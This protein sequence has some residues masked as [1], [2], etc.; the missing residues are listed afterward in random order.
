MA[1]ESDENNTL[2]QPLP[3][4]VDTSPPEVS[5]A[6]PADGASRAQVERISFTLLDRYGGSVDTAAVSASVVVTDDGG[7]L[8]DGVL[9]AAG[10]QF[11]FTPA[12]VPLADGRYRVG[13]SAVDTAGNA[14]DHALVF[15]VDGDAPGGL[16]ITGGGVASGVIQI[17]PVTNRAKSGS[18]TLT[19][20]REDLTSV[21]VNNRLRVAMGTGDWSTV[22]YLPEGESALEV[23]LQDGAGNRSASVWVDLLVDSVAPAVRSLL[24]ADGSFLK[25]APA[26]IAVEFEEATSGLDPAGCLLA[27]H[28][29]DQAPVS[30]D[31]TAAGNQLS[32][33]PQ[34]E[35]AE[36]SYTVTLQ[37]QD[38]LGN[39]AAAVQSHF[40]LDATP[41][42][43][44]AVDPVASP[45]PTITQVIGGSKEA[46]A[47]ILLNGAEVVGHSPE[48]TWECTANLVSGPNRLTFLARDRAGN[49]SQG[50][51]VEIVCDDLPPPAVSALTADGRGNGTTVGLSWAGYDEAAHGDVAAYRIYH[52]TQ[53]FVDVSGLSARATAAAGQFTWRAEGLVKG[54]VYWF[55][56]V[57]V[58]RLGNALSAVSPVSAA[59]SDV[60]APEDVAGLAVNAHDDRLRFTWQP[61]ADSAGDLA[62]YRV[63]FNAAA[64]GE[65]LSAE[66]TAFEIGGLNPATAYPFRICAVDHDGNQSAG[67]SLTGITLL[68]N[69]PGLSADAHSGCVDLVWQAVQPAAYVKHYRVY[70]SQSAFATVAGMRPVF[71]TGATS[72]R[73]AGLTDHTPYWFAVTTVNLTGGERLSVVPVSATP[74]A[75]AEGPQISS[76]RVGETLLAA[77]H[78]FERSA[79]I[80]VA[81]TDPAGVSRVT[82]SI[83]GVVFATAYNA[84]YSGFLDIAPIEDGSHTVSIAAHDTLGNSTTLEFPI[85][86]VMAPPEAPRITQ[87]LGG[88]VTSQPAMTVSGRAEKGATVR[89]YL[90]AAPH[91]SPIAVDV[92]GH[93]NI[94]ATLVEGENRLWAAAENR[95]GIGP[96]SPEVRVTLD[97]TLPRS[98]LGLSAQARAGGEVRLA[99]QMPPQERAAGF[100]VY[101][102]AGTFA[103][104]A[105]AEKVTAQPITAT[106]FDDLPPQDGT[107]YYRVVAVDAALNQGAPSNEA[108]AVSDGTPPRALA[109][110]YAPQGKVDSVSGAMA[111]GRVLVDLTV[112]EALQAAPFL[113]ITP[114]GGLPVAVDLTQAD[115]TRYT[116]VFTIFEST[117]TATAYAVFSARDRAGN[118]GT[119][120]DDGASIAIDTDGPDV[121][122]LS[123]APPEPIK[124]DPDNPVIIS[125]DIG[126][127]EA[128]EAGT[129]PLIECRLSGEGRP[130]LSVTAP[131]EIAPR[132]GERQCW[133]ARVALPADAG[134]EAPETLVVTY[135][136]RDALENLGD[137]ILCQN[138]FQIYQGGLPPLSPPEGVVATALPGGRIRLNWQAVEDA[139]GYQIYRQAPGENALAA[140]LRCDEVLEWVDDPGQE[141]L[142][143]Y[144]IASV[145]QVN[146]ETAESAMSAPS[147]EALADA[148]P[149]EAPWDLALELTAQGVR[150]A[151]QA[152]AGTE[153]L[154]YRLYR[155][156]LAAITT[157]ADLSPVITGI[158]QPATVDSR[159]SP[160]AHSYVATAVDAA[161]NESAPSNSAYLNAGLL[162]VATL[163]VVQTD[164]AAPV[165]SWTHPG[166]GAVGFDLFLGAPDGGIRL[167]PALLTGAAFTDTGWSGDA[168]AYT[169]VAV[170]ANNARSLGRTVNLPLLETSLGAA[171]RLQRGV[172]NRLV[173]AV[174]NR[175]AE[176]VANVRLKT[177]LAGREHLSETFAVA[178]GAVVHVPVT[179][180][181][182][183]ELRDSEDLL[184]TLEITPHEGE[185]VRIA[186]T[187]EIPVDDGA[188]VLQVLTD[189]F[190]RGGTGEVRFALTNTGDSAIEIV[191]ARSTGKAAS[192]EITF[193]LLDAD[194]NVL[195]V[196]AFKQALG[197]GVVTLA[198]GV[199]VARMGA[200]ETFTSE[201][202]ALPVP[203][204]AP[205][206]GVVRL[207]I[208]GVYHHL[209]RDDEVVMAGPG[210]RYGVTL[211][212]TAYLGEVTGI[213]PQISTG[214][215]TVVINGRALA[216]DS[217]QPMPHV[218][219]KLIITLNGFERSV[220]VFS[221]ADGTFAHGFT[222]LAGEGGT[223]A[224]GAVH[225]DVTDRPLQG[226][227]VISKLS[228]SPTAATL[229]LPKNY[230]QR[231]TLE[232]TAGDGREIRNLQ[233]VWAATDQPEGVLPQG[234][235]L[236]P[237]APVSVLGPRQSAE[238]AFSVW[239]D[240]TAAQSETLVLRVQSDGDA[241]PITWARVPITA[242]FSEAA[243]F[244]SVNPHHLETGVAL[245]SSATESLVLAN[246]GT[247]GI[248][249]LM[250][251]LVTPDGAPAPAWVQLNSPADLGTLAV[252]ESREVTLTFAPDT[253]V[254][255]GHHTFHLRAQGANLQ[256]VDTRLFVAMTQS[257]IGGA[258]FKVYD[259]YTGT[260][261]ADTRQPIQGLKGAR[262]AL[263]HETVASLQAAEITDG[264]GEALF[265]ELPAGRYKCRITAPNHQETISRVS[266]KPGLTTTR[267]VFL[268]Y[269]LVTV[270]WSVSETTIADSYEIVLS[271]TFETDVP[272][273]VVVAEPASLTLPEMRAGD[274]LNGEFTLSNYGL[275]RADGL[276][277]ILP[278]D[279]HHF[280]YEIL[281]G[282]PDQ[283][284]AKERIRVPY[285]LTCLAPLNPDE[286]GEASGGGC[287]SYFKAIRTI[288]SWICANGIWSGGSTRHAFTY[289]V[290]SGCGGAGGSV[291]W[292]GIPY[293]DGSAGSGGGTRPE[294]FIGQCLPTPPKSPCAG[295]V[296]CAAGNEG[297]QN[298]RDDTAPEVN[299]L[300]REYTAESVDI[301]VKVPGGAV[302][303]G[304]RYRGFSWGWT[305]DQDNLHFERD[306]FDGSLAT[307]EKDGVRYT[308][309]SP[310]AN[311]FKNQSYLIK[312]EA[313][314]FRWEDKLGDWKAFD[315]TGRLAAYGNRKGTI[316]R[317]VYEPLADGKLLGYADRDGRIVLSMEYDDQ[318]RLCGIADDNGRR[319]VYSYSGERLTEVTNVLG[320]R[321]AF[322]YDASGRISRTMDDAGRTRN[323]T[324]NTYGYVTSVLDD[325]GRGS[326]FEYDYD[327]LRQEYYARITSTTGRE[328]EVWY[329]RDGKT[330]RVDIN[331]RTVQKIERDGRTLLVTDEKGHTTRK[332]FDQW[333]NLT[334]VVHPDGATETTAYEHT[335]NK[336]VQ[337][338]DPNGIITRYEYDHAGNTTRIVE[339]AGTAAERVTEYA[340]DGDNNRT[341][342]RRLGD[343]RTA[344]ALTSM[345]YDF[346]G[347]MISLTDPEGNTSRF[348]HDNMGN[349]LSREDFRGKVWR[350]EYNAAGLVTTIIDPLNQETRFEYDP[351]GNR[352][353][354]VDPEGIENTFAYDARGNLTAAANGTGEVVRFEYNALNQMTRR[355]DPEGK[356]LVWDYDPD[357][358]LAR[359]ID[360]NGNVIAMDYEALYASCAGCSGGGQAAKPSKTI[361]PTFTR[362]YRY[363]KRGRKTLEMDVL[364]PDQEHTTRFVYDTAG[365]LVERTDQEDHTIRY[366]YN[367][368]GR[369]VLEI[370]PLGH[371]I[372]YSYDARDNLVALL[373]P[374]GGNTRFEYDRNNRL[375]R[376][377]R[378]EGQQTRYG[379]DPAGN[380]IEKIDAKNQKTVYSYDDAGR[381]VETRHHAAADWNTA[382][383]TVRYTY[384][385]IGNLIGYHDGLTAA[386]YTFDD[387]HRKIAETLD[388]GPFSLSYGYEYYANG[389]KKSFTAPDGTTYQYTYDAN[390][391][392]TGVALPGAGFFTVNTHRWNRPE[393]IS[394]PGG[395]SQRYDYD[396]L[397]R[398]RSITVEDPGKKGLMDYHYTYD[399]MD[400]ITLKDTEHGNY[401]Y[402]YDPLYRLLVASTPKE[403]ETFTYDPLGNRLTAEGV[404]GNW[405][406]NS[407]NEL[408]G[409][410]DLTFDYDANGNMIRKTAD[411]R[412]LNYIYNTE[413]RL[414]G[415]EES[416]AEAHRR[417]RL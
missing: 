268:E 134:L 332:T 355:V 376:E 141:G 370:D 296:C 382:V 417:I 343:S 39:R 163:D 212:D 137:R 327:K 336:P 315:D 289:A 24:P 46:Y 270:A 273:A 278:Q 129:L 19:G 17:R 413:D 385:R 45:T 213:A 214:D 244:L 68:E 135:Q 323:I 53:P 192:D 386:F 184:T 415:V 388:Y 322:E 128:L 411:G 16:T 288:Y 186:R 87:P 391:Q 161:G 63:F 394:L 144:A 48:T 236:T 131:S 279:D 368:L 264:S 103:A 23:W 120:I 249:N 337:K 119:E 398:I 307:I 157:V 290:G 345:A 403:D 54:V 155:S 73:V 191:T 167:N 37:L 204:N 57:A 416:E 220:A 20:T 183:G 257:G 99:W 198:N 193:Y 231:I 13:F 121:I 311:V 168:R 319:V 79:I 365:R 222:P 360:G 246:K 125:L 165:V 401:S 11:T 160:T 114:E 151:W 384:D 153:P 159:P 292:S 12:L 44:P 205:D 303:A 60:L 176:A 130:P 122:R 297:E 156:D 59:P 252:G 84:P 173:Y 69:P 357:G 31:W 378:P 269:N 353:K 91:G 354:M 106:I 35:M 409:Y 308:A 126:L 339:A 82:F 83:D 89:L 304:R 177:I 201:P 334:A 283:L 219:L 223:Y 400:N 397:M 374:N 164:N 145:R 74:L 233:L 247:A 371:E 162:P 88:A 261:D 227:F 94:R 364:G 47:A 111:P 98:P 238:L 152:P 85:Q 274:V 178:P 77:G 380:L 97:T 312:K 65:A 56:V 136:G 209:G 86:I 34:N 116:G 33:V 207:E 414:V 362:E 187:S 363:D 140:C 194:D 352:V 200:G 313:A 389:M 9:A 320:N 75:D 402:R 171:A 21:W 399:R 142:F 179:V 346:L 14:R 230:P 324:Y 375:V 71:A 316:A 272:A 390:N 2:W 28:D 118:R 259:I 172:M 254:S 50:A 393:H 392:L 202:V 333:D 265:P 210:T 263:Q 61:S 350:H 282:L 211:V 234:V 10:D 218:P 275:V 251:S 256:P 101:R 286:D 139:A 338:T 58:D 215:Q 242:H 250:L 224:V 199:S 43:A 5:H 72:A 76:V 149:P 298:Q 276:K 281:G 41:P 123:L 170:D 408:L 387:A 133:Q 239:A 117:P 237:E 27:L 299:L 228:V 124:N 351:A 67:A 359:S 92:Q 90:N 226:H 325:E 206:A 225:P 405:R 294:T 293:G 40:T 301:A 32:F 284:G 330:R 80:T 344:E 150:A 310:D 381:L 235:H 248:S 181:G 113:S 190:T 217:G 329:D 154:T 93:F 407:N 132:P 295:D 182:Y 396:P 258:L 70:V 100:V 25:L 328:K 64:E 29:G 127:N 341:V 404:P 169:L 62:G 195:S 229:N 366:V 105:A 285:R 42:P 379:Y 349:V 358:R 255:E 280:R 175:S 189:A 267:E 243:P 367:E 148:T 95:A 166:G 102:S 373:D 240:N 188:L 3:T 66:Q 305:H 22:L 318:G 115:E 306:D 158:T 49:H 287:F 383:K 406:Y 348:T 185:T 30:G 321:Q 107:W 78:R 340:Y 104:V 262:V 232:A 412:V 52:E 291:Y 300:S 395:G 377:I 147:V 7:G 253:T 203:A 309:A 110:H 245:G 342:I 96:A 36:S 221:A 314:G 241:G 317:M 196:A 372:Q 146:G 197:A 410:G 15:T 18:I 4:V 326:Y 271:A 361:F 143:R 260:L 347:N 266:I 108:V 81:A 112:S 138:R 208:D 335:F 369:L 331:G 180:G 302:A 356:A 8:V 1:E 26:A 174:E 51:A 38:A 216:R 109:I 6:D 55:A 277:I